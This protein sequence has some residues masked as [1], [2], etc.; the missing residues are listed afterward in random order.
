MSTAHRSTAGIEPRRIAEIIVATPDGRRRGS[1][2]RVTG[3]CVLTAAHVVSDATEVTVRCDAD[4]PGEWSATAQV[5]WADPATDLAVLTLERPAGGDPVEPAR[6]ARVPE[7]R[8]AVVPVHAAG[9]PL[10]KQR[11]R[12]GGGAF[13]ELHQ[14]DGTVAALSNLRTG[15]LE[16]TVAPAGGDPDPRSSPWAG[17][18][19]AALWAGDAIVGVIAEHHRWE[20]SG[21]LT[22]VRIDTALRQADT[23]AATALAGLLGVEAPTDLPLVRTPDTPHVAGDEQNAGSERPRKRV[24]GLPVA[25]GIE[26]FKNRTEQL[27]RAGWHLADPTIR[28]VSVV[29]RRGM[30]KSALAAKLMEQL[31]RGAWPGRTRIPVVS[32]LVN[33]STRTSG[34]SLERLFFD[35]A[36]LLPAD[37]RRHLESVWA[38]G[39][40]VPDKVQELFEALGDRLV[41][42]LMDNFEDLLTDEGDIT[43]EEIAVFLDCLFRTGTAPRLLITTQI[44]VRLKPELRRFAAQVELTEGLGADEAVELLRELD[45]DGALGLA[46]LSDEELLSASV[47]VHGVPRALELM[48]G[49]LADQS[50]ELPTLHQ[51]LEDFVQRENVVEALAH[52][53]YRR[54][55]G[56]SRTVL[57]VLAALRTPVSR[58]ALEEIVSRIDPEV[59]LGLALSKLLHVRLVSAHRAT[60]TFSLH[61]MDAD[62]AYAGMPLD[63][64][65]GRRTTERRIADWYA[66]AAMPAPAWRTL[67]D[68]EPLRRQFLHLV[69]AGDHDDA[70]MVLGEISEWMVWKGSVLTALSF[71]AVIDGLV[72][73]DRARLT[74]LIAYGHA[75][76]SGGPMEQALD[77]FRQGAELARRLDDPVALQS[78]VFG[79]G[80]TYRQLGR[81]E[82]SVEPLSEASALARRSGDTE[83]E[84]HALLSLSLTLSYLHRGE[85]AL[86]A[87]DELGAVAS[88]TGQPLTDARAWNA[89]TIALLTLGRWEE[90]VRSGARAAEAYRAAGSQEAIAYALNAQG[91]ALLAL[92]RTDEARAAL[93]DALRE[94][95]LMENPRAEGVCLC[96]LAWAHWKAGDWDRSAESAERASPT[97]QIAGAAER[98]AAVDLAEAARAMGRSEPGTAA[99][100]LTRA[101]GALTGNAEVITASW[102][103]Q[104]AEHLRAGG[105][106]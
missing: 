5:S 6:F 48:V 18:S 90:T 69:R 66:N 41:V 2:Y 105:A 30:G 70:A 45:R 31:D 81:P 36:R 26:L 49:A 85:E 38:S 98:A 56:P 72:H 21:R 80:D 73:D 22:A 96:N 99:T 61:P 42:I 32:G 63:G 87:A 46:E 71:H 44:P 14:A 52:D 101:A 93:E 62:L 83:T 50:I 84:I 91:L 75:R 34:I 77:L 33:L 67:D 97:L 27:A 65:S 74:H 13:R 54:L 1:G 100:A 25:H 24:I 28:M 95:S 60:R 92:R 104:E 11:R 7:E 12:P 102:L 94:A 59:D 68:L 3:A 39:L 89:R 35:C 47:R 17:M 103:L 76:L 20:G 58:G 23:A 43:D 8:H 4:R 19:G 15:T 78:A 10:W 106:W 55:D 51:V 29:G 82:D 37:V 57:Q 79:L 86:A 53:R 40:P 88:R 16:I 64:P 9:F